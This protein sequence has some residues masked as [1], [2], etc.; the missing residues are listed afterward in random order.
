MLHPG[1]QAKGGFSGF[2]AI[3]A[4][5][6]EY[7]LVITEPVGIVDIHLVV[8]RIGGLDQSGKIRSGFTACVVIQVCAGASESRMLMRTK[9]RL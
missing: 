3:A 4:V 9:N 2:K 1:T 7:I 6:T 5:A 8:F